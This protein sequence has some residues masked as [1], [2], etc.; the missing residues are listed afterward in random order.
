MRSCNLPFLLI[1]LPGFIISPF[2][3]CGQSEQPSGDADSNNRLT[4]GNQAETYKTGNSTEIKKRIES[5]YGDLNRNSM[6]GKVLDNTR[7]QPVPGVDY[8]F[9]D[10]SLIKGEE[11]TIVK[12]LSDRN[13][14]LVEIDS[15]WGL[16]DALFIMPI[17][18][19]SGVIPDFVP[20]ESP[21]ELVS[22]LKIVYPE[23]AKLNSVQ[24]KVIVRAFIDKKG[25]LLK[26]EILKGDEL[27]NQAALDAIE[28]ARFKPARFR[29]KSIGAWIT[30]PVRFRLNSNTIF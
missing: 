23:K 14:W 15:D 13:A 6:K 18:D 20:F 8:N 21:P 7:L 3:S 1:I 30:I 27:L 29:G 22:P 11:I 4:E 19:E 10:Y 9:T 24:G 16:I 26:S 5:V 17:Q 12:Y 2:L 25:K 28:N